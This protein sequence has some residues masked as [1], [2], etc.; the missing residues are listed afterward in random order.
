MNGEEVVGTAYTAGNTWGNAFTDSSIYLYAKW[1]PVEYICT[2]D[3]NGGIV[4]DTQIVFTYFSDIDLPIPTSTE[5]VFLAWEK[6]GQTYETLGGFIGD[7]TLNASWK[8]GRR[9]YPPA[10]FYKS[11]TRCPFFCQRMVIV[12]RPLTC[13]STEKRPSSS[14]IAE[15]FLP[16]ISAT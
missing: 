7:I 10:C 3:Y 11:I 5:R 4:Q 14:R 8:T 9:I 1:S 2:L 13:S 16:P 6:D 15:T 12:S